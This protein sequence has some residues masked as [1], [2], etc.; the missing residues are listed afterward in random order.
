[1]TIDGEWLVADVG[2]TNT[3]VAAATPSGMLLRVERFATADCAGAEALLDRALQMLDMKGPTGCCLAIAGP[4]A[5]GR[6]ALTNAPLAFDA[7]GLSAYLGAPVQLVNDFHAQAMAL[8]HLAQ[9]DELGGPNAVDPQ[10]VK[11]VLGPGSGLGMG[12]LLPC[13]DGWRVLPSEGGHADLAPASPLEVELLQLLQVQHRHVCWETV[14]S[15]PGLVALY[16]AMCALW[17]AEPET[18]TPEDVS[19][20][21]LDAGDPVCHQTLETFFSLLGTAAGNL[22]LIYCATGGVYVGGG[23]VPQLREFARHSPLRR[24]FDER[25][26]LASY[27]ETIPLYLIGDAEPG[28][29]GALAC[30]RQR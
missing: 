21:G 9:L 15:G 19:A 28:L 11:A 8:P 27:A 3:R 24:R 1:M 20:R 5:G 22:A 4:V 16:R 12:A 17:G 25:G 7:S 23:I 10:G 2:A 30:L 29:L 26:A 14:L 6:G 18:L 13:A